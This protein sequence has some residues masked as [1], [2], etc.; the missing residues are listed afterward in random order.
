MRHP[1]RS[2]TAI[3]LI[4]SLQLRQCLADGLAETGIAH[5]PVETSDKPA[6]LTDILADK[7]LLLQNEIAVPG[8]FCCQLK[9]H[10]SMYFH[11]QYPIVVTTGNPEQL[12]GYFQTI[13]RQSIVVSPQDA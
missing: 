9:L 12:T 5:S 3:F 11:T 7:V 10:S 2:L 13:C 6:R 8:L 1:I 4:H